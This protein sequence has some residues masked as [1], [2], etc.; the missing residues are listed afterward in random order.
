MWFSLVGDYKATVN[1]SLSGFV[2]SS[3]KSKDGVWDY[4]AQCPREDQI[5]SIDLLALVENVIV[6]PGIRKWLE[7]ALQKV[8]HNAFDSSLGLCSIN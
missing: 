4:S 1:T 6:Y 5:V 2:C 3:R 8:S 7:E